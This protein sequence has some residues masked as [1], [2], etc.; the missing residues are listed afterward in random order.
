MEIIEQAYTS[1][2]SLFKVTVYAKYS[3]EMESPGNWLDNVEISRF[4]HNRNKKDKKNNN[5]AARAGSTESSSWI[6]YLIIVK[7]LR[8]IV[9]NLI[10]SHEKYFF[11]EHWLGSNE[12]Y[13]FNNIPMFK[14]FNI[15]MFK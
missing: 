12:D 2:F 3:V 10:N 8:L 9:E 15:P 6:L 13:L 14:L 11:I 5:I 1:H 4:F 7:I